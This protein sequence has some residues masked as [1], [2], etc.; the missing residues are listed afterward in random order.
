MQMQL[1][2]IFDEDERERDSKASLKV[3]TNCVC[4]RLDL[5]ETSKVIQK[6]NDVTQRQIVFHGDRIVAS[7][8][9]QRPQVKNENVP[10]VL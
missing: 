2:K 10:R 8:L 3:E 1:Q 9:N 5:S 4:M 6:T 7:T